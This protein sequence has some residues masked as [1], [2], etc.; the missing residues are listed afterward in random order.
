MIDLLV[1]G[2]SA[3]D[4]RGLQRAVGDN[5]DG[6]VRGLRVSGKAV[7]VG[8]A[9]ATASAAKRIFLLQPR[10]VILLGTCGIY[11]GIAGYQPLDVLVP[12]RLVAFD[13]ACDAGLATFPNTMTTEI[14]PTPAMAAGLAGQRAHV[15]A[16][17]S[18][19]AVT[20]SDDTAAALPARHR[21]DAE[22]VEAFGVATACALARIPF[23]AVLAVTHLV[24]STAKQDFAKHH[25]DATLTAAEVLLTWLH[26]GAAGLPHG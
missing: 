7:G 24:G 10:A 15:V 22:H 19:P 12:N 25:R 18:P 23:G 1:V 21:C 3:P 16:V 8:L 20:T 13:H 11:P 26:G 9:A 2:T 5:L 6:D 14:T 4:L 17:G